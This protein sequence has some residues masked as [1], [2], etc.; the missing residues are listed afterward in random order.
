M[1]ITWRAKRAL[2]LERRLED[3]EEHD[4]KDDQV[5]KHI[6]EPTGKRLKD[7]PH[8]TRD[9]SIKKI[10]RGLDDKLTP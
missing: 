8:W 4:G 2:S 7:A 6:L 10:S 1:Y 5:L 3:L 9:E